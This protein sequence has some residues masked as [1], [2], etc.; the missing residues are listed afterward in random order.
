MTKSKLTLTPG[1]FY[2]SKNNQ[3]WCCFNV[4]MTKEIHAQADCIRLFDER[5][6]YFYIDGK[7]DSEGKRE[8]TLI[9]QVDYY[10]DY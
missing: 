4:D 6:E 3:L 9:K 2:K 8:H 7:Y 5:I 10:S 1:L